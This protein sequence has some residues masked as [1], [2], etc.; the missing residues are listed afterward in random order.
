[1]DRPE[2]VCYVCGREMS[3]PRNELGFKKMRHDTCKP[4]S[5]NWCIWY[6]AHPERHTQEGDLI[7]ASAE[8][9]RAKAC[10]KLRA[11]TK[12]LKEKKA[13]EERQIWGKS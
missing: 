9:A 12:R 4:G 8:K 13:A 1:M 7:R 3:K 2:G 6:D 10:E 5:K 11:L